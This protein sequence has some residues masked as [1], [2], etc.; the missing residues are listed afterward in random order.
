MHATQILASFPAD[1]WTSLTLSKQ[2]FYGIALAAAVVV[3][4]LGILSMF[5]IAHDVQLDA[6]DADGG[7]S[8][9]S[10]KPITGFLFAFGWAGGAT[11]SAGHSLLL[12]CILALLAGLIVMFAIAALLR[13]SQRL[14]VDGTI[15][16]E[17][18]IG[19]IATVYI[20]IPPAPATGGQIT[21]PLDGRTIT[22]GAL[23]AGAPPIPA[24]AKVKVLALIDP[25]TARVELI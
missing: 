20:T 2:V 4:I 22:L 13:A 7:S 17:D 8:L 23:Q 16:K 14:K 15:K 3:I 24:D 5:G 25:D 1:W 6:H 10:L 19:K 18:A 11:L 9:F 12:A 21:V